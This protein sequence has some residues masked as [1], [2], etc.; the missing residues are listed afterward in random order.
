MIQTMNS[1]EFNIFF[2][3]NLYSIFNKK[4]KSIRDSDHEPNQAQYC[5][6]LNFRK[7]H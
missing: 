7:K 6:P 2:P 4:K 5:F 1:I 3:L